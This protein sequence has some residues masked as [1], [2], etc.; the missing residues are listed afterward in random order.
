MTGPRLR[1][2]IAV[3]APLAVAAPAPAAGAPAGPWSATVS[4]LASIQPG[5]YEGP[6]SPYLSKNLGGTRAG[7]SLAVQRGRPGQPLL[8]LELSTSLAIEAVQSG[9]F[10]FPSA[11]AVC[12]EFHSC[13]AL[14]SHRDTLLSLLVG[15]A[16]SGG[17][18]ELKAGPSLVLAR[19][20]QGD[21]VYDDAAGHLALTAAMDG[22][23][24]LGRR[25]DLVP[26]VRYSYVLRGPNKDSVGINNHIVR[27]AVGLRIR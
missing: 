16:T 25:V 1:V 22:V 3:L 5:G 15:G 6:G 26:G 19:T 9:R 7:L 8:A 14:G 20:R 27:L 13:T 18:Y 12:S 24:A 21:F 4:G 10:V 17:L 11:S 2:L 23:I